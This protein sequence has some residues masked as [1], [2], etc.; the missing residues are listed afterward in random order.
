MHTVATHPTP[1]FDMY[2]PGGT[3]PSTTSFHTSTS[4]AQHMLRSPAPSN[5]NYGPAQGTPRT[6]N[7]ARPMQPAPAAPVQSYGF[8][9]ELP[10][11]ASSTSAATSTARF[12]CRWSRPGFCPV[13]LEGDKNSVARHLRECHGFV[14]DGE[15]VVCAWEQCD[16]PLQRRNIAR[17]IVACHLEVKVYCKSCGIPLSRPDAGKK[18]EKYCTTKGDTQQGRPANHH[19]RMSMS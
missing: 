9:E 10:Q 12:S 5:A 6:Q 15:T 18:H 13:S 19:H 7:A 14:C 4:Y 16:I 8:S 3:A 17:H 11:P 2:P 1:S